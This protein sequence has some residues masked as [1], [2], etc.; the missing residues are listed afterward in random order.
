MLYLLLTER[1]MLHS[2]HLLESA[3]SCLTPALCTSETFCPFAGQGQP[4]GMPSSEHP[5]QNLWGSTSYSHSGGGESLQLPTIQPASPLALPLTG[6]SLLSLGG[7]AL[8]RCPRCTLSGWGT[9]QASLDCSSFPLHHSA[10]ARNQLER[11]RSQDGGI[12]AGLTWEPHN[13]LHAL[14]CPLRPSTG[15]KQ[16]RL[17]SLNKTF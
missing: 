12:E 17:Q 6:Y 11:E 15:Q 7:Q 14:L 2:C 9:C 10:C 16:G 8:Q 4:P 3:P 1:A 5:T 13:V